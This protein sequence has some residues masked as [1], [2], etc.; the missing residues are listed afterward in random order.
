MQ[1]RMS[2][3]QRWQRVA[4]RQQLLQRPAP[5]NAKV[6]GEGC[7]M[8]YPKRGTEDDWEG[9]AGE[10]VCEAPRRLQ[11]SHSQS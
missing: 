11:G 3:R 5:H 2:G 6:C 7:C 1:R 9:K 8:L 10:D 4:F